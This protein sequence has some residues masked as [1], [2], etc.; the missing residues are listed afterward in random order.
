MDVPDSL[1][2]NG[3]SLKVLEPL[4]N[5]KTIRASVTLL[6]GRTLEEKGLPNYTLV[7]QTAVT[8]VADGFTMNEAI[9][10]QA[11]DRLFGIYECNP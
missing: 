10:L 7:G 5:I 4:V 2:Y 8:Q 3:L 9:E 6:V 1:E 11:G